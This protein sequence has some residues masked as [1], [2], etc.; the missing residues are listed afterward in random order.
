MLNFD[1]VL[2]LSPH[3]DDVELG[4]GGTVHK[5]ISNGSHVKL[6]AFS[7]CENP[8]LRDEFKKG[9]EALG[10]QD[11]TLLEF[12]RRKFPKYRQDILDYLWELQIEEKFNLV[13]TPC[14]FDVHQDHQTIHRETLRAFRKTA[15]I[16]GYVMNWNAP[17]SRVDMY[18]VLDEKDVQA[19]LKA[20][21][22]Y[23]SQRKRLANRVDVHEAIL[24][25]NGVC[26]DE[27]YA[28]AF[29]TIRQIWI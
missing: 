1:K 19:K 11:S 3:T 24:R 5:L 23:G 22:V 2:A 13:L 16:W 8:T 26:V 4:A 12:P 21:S 6:V 15:T 9:V 25:S 7:W 28:E 18:V 20:I 27:Q 29:E 17:T 14:S 10:V